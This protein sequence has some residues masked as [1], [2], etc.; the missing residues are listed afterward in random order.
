LLTYKKKFRNKVVLGLSDHT[1]GHTT[2]L[3]A[4]ALGAKVIEKHFTDDNNRKGPDHYF[5]MNPKNW[6]EMVKETRRL[7]AALGSGKKIVEK[8][9]KKTNLIQRRGSYAARDLK[10]KEII[11][12]DDIIFLRPYFKGSISPFTNKKNFGK[13]KK[14]I[15]KGEFIFRK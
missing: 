13:S 6:S 11:K 1:Q 14:T 2:V 12:Y 3:G 4:V 10:K 7:E 8:N 5:S 15:N 9:E